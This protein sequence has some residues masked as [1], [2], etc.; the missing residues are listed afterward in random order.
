LTGKRL[1]QKKQAVLAMGGP[2]LQ[3]RRNRSN[4]S[5]KA[6]SFPDDIEVSRTPMAWLV[7]NQNLAF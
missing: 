1:T 4:V 5:A 6:E 7:G 2:S 3:F